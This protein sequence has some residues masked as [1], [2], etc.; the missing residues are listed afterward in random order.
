MLSMSG[1]PVP[2]GCVSESNLVCERVLLSRIHNFFQK[3]DTKYKLPPSILRV[4]QLTLKIH[5]ILWR[6]WSFLEMGF[7]REKSK[8]EVM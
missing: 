4:N 6:C 5:S 8:P 1:L 3:S 2:F 7:R